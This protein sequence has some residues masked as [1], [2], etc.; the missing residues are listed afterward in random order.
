[1]RV[2]FRV[3]ETMYQNALAAE[4]LKFVRWADAPNRDGFILIF[5]NFAGFENR[6]GGVVSKQDCPQRWESQAQNDL[7]HYLINH[8]MC[9]C[10][11]L[12]SRKL[13]VFVITC[14]LWLLAAYR[15]RQGE[16]NAAS[17]CFRVPCEA[18]AVHEAQTMPV[19][20]FREVNN[21]RGLM[22]STIYRNK[23]P[24]RRCAD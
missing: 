17:G 5:R 7:V 19:A 16:C 22:H 18:G 14:R 4:N 20:H 9:S 1:M 10:M 8:N 21:F 3:W 6:W 23:P 12:L 13:T 11:S 24:L 15:P 2:H